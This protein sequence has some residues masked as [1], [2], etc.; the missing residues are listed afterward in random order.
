MGSPLSVPVPVSS[1]ALG[2]GEER[3]SGGQIN[4]ERLPGGGGAGAWSKNAYRLVC[5]TAGLR[6]LGTLVEER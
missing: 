2:Q 4:Q 5:P 1:V 6:A 3:E